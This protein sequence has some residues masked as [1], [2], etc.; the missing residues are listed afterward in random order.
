MKSVKCFFINSKFEGMFYHLNTSKFYSFFRLF[1]IFFLDTKH[2]W[3]T[4]LI[5]KKM[6]KKNSNFFGCDQMNFH[7]GDSERWID[8]CEEEKLE[9]IFLIR[10]VSFRL[11]DSYRC[12][13]LTLPASR[14]SIVRNVRN[15]VLFP[16]KVLCFVWNVHFYWGF[17]FSKEH[18]IV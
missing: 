17:R 14:S 15:S 11:V 18:K 7:D 1:P 10:F 13:R 12:V 4:K 3:T 8:K 9:S 16:M 2:K 6:S 5:Q